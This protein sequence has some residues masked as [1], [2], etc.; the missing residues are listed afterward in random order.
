MSKQTDKFLSL[1]KDYETI[2]RD[3][4]EDPKLVE[5]A[6]DEVRGGRMRLCRQFRNYLSHSND[7]GFLEPTDAMV[8]FLENELKEWQMKEDIA[9]KHL[10]SVAASICTISARCTDVME[11][12]IKLQTDKLVIYDDKK[13]DF[14]VVRIWDVS[15]TILHSRSLKLAGN[16]KLSNQKVAIVSPYTYMSDID[17]NTVTICTSDGTK[18]GKLLGTVWFK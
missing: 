9:K 11:K 18:E 14:F 7:P 3:A 1:Y 10:K 4:G 13:K 12:M 8:K 15:D 5:D 16:V 2:I 6:M 17:K